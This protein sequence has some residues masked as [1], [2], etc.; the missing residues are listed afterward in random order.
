M[1]YTMGIIP[2]QLGSSSI[3]VVNK[4]PEDTTHA[5][6]EGSNVDDVRT[7]T[8]EERDDT[9]K[10]DNNVLEREITSPKLLVSI[11]NNSTFIISEG[12]SI[13][14]QTGEEAFN[15]PTIEAN[16]GVGDIAL[17]GVCNDNSTCTSNIN[18]DKEVSAFSGDDVDSIKNTADGTWDEDT[19]LILKNLEL[20]KDVSESEINSCDN[21]L[22]AFVETSDMSFPTVVQA[23][24]LSPRPEVPFEEI[25]LNECGKYK[26]RLHSDKEKCMVSSSA[27][28]ETG[29]VVVI[30]RSNQKLKY[31]DS[32]FQ[33]I[34]SYE[35]STTPWAVCARRND[36]YVTLGN[37]QIQH[38]VIVDMTVEPGEVFET[39]GRCLGICVY[40]EY[41]AVGVQGGEIQLLDFHGE[42]QTTIELPKT[43]VGKPCSPWHLCTSKHENIL[44]TD[45]DAGMVVCINE[46]SE[47]VFIF[48]GMSS[49]RATAVDYHGN[50]L[51][52]G[53]D[54]SSAGVAM[55]LHKDMELLNMLHVDAAT[56]ERTL[57]TWET[58]EFVPYC[59]SYRPD[60]V[61][62]LGGIQTYLKIMRLGEREEF[63]E[64]D[65]DQ[66]S[67]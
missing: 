18:Q 65:T 46:A 66:N 62:V 49:P 1:I 7:E 14:T 19:N 53:R 63:A 41:L 6:V 35:F 50:I 21:T 33:F 32:K 24:N 10:R 54:M 40:K 28:M 52:V 47:V 16:A 43:E 20:E 30:D 38:L 48:R 67:D 61:V 22:T 9:R 26:V 37:T 12:R 27:F 44:V 11:V 42:M 17:A 51:L 29:D 58:L 56:K 13:G 55:V 59:V 3:K 39:T 5:S 36:V 31:V 45:S 64:S 25:T 4:L 23:R 15:G 2:S 57:L 8:S 34:S 60:D